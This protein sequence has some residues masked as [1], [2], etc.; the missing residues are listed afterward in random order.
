MERNA[1]TPPS[2][3]LFHNPL[4]K[5]LGK[6]TRFRASKLV[7][8]SAVVPD[9]VREAGFDP[10]HLGDYGD[11]KDGWRI[12]GNTPPSGFNRRAALAYY[13]A[14]ADHP[15]NPL[16]IQASHRGH[17][18]LTRAGIAAS[19]LLCR[20]NST[21]L[22]LEER[23][24]GPKGLKGPFWN[25]LRNSISKRLPKSAEADTV[26]DHIQNCWL[27]M[28]RLD[29]LRTRIE[30]GLHINASHLITYATRTAFTDIRNMGTEPV[31]RELYG[32]RTERE[33][34]RGTYLPPIRDSRLSGYRKSAT[35]TTWVDVV[36]TGLTLDERV[37]FEQMWL[38]V[39]KVIRTKKPN[40]GARYVKI[41]EALFKGFTVKDIASDE[42]VSPYRAAGIIAEARRCMREAAKDGMLAAYI[43]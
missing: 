32:A 13:H 25:H 12:K 4:I 15:K 23:L 9:M 36:D 22:F 37:S 43:T 34:R 30:A 20:K 2:F 7:P 41:V 33:R 10:D 8:M 16:S 40:A 3:R 29:A 31:C 39:E 24:K 6:V 1:A 38:L 42:T 35:A 28:I 19:K 14:H 17:W 21:A 26:D 18:G 11:P 27:K 5:I